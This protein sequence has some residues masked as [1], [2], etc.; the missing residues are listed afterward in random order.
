MVSADVYR[1][2]AIEAA[3][4]LVRQS[5]RVLSIEVPTRSRWRSRA[6]RLRLRVRAFRFVLIVDTAGRPCI[7]DADMMAEIQALHAELKPS[8]PCSWSMP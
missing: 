6:R 2:A 3:E 7:I 8:R 1:P 5:V 4:D